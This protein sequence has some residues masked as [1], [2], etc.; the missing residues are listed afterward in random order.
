M[1]DKKPK[2][3]PELNQEDEMTPADP[4]LQKQPEVREPDKQKAVPVKM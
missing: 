4:L 1:K 3:E 2:E